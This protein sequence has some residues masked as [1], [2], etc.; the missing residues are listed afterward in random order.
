MK[1]QSFL[2]P[3]SLP[4]ADSMNYQQIISHVLV[5]NMMLV[6]LVSEFH[7]SPCN[8]FEINDSRVTSYIYAAVYLH[9]VGNYI[10]FVLIQKQFPDTEILCT[11]VLLE[12]MTSPSVGQYYL[13]PSRSARCLGSLYLSL[14]MGMIP[15]SD[16]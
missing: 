4:M 15:F 9:M 13:P 12:K 5:R 11:N 10:L 2:Y 8:N 7:A 16:L 1:V 6:T 3:C 14:L